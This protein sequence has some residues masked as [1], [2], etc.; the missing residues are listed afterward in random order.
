MGLF[1]HEDP[2]HLASGRKA[3]HVPQD[4]GRFNPP[5]EARFLG[6]HTGSKAAA[7]RRWLSLSYNF[8][9]EEYRGEDHASFDGVGLVVASLAGELGGAAMSQATIRARVAMSKSTCKRSS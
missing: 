3:R 1:S 9:P 8:E 6:R 7:K 2:S 5:G 4:A